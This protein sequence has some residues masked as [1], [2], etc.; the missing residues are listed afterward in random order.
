MSAEPKIIIWDLETL[1]NLTE[2]MKFMP[3]MY[4]YCTLRASLSTIICFGYKQLGWKNSKC[5]N[6]WDFPNWQK[7]VN[8]D[9]E[10]CSAAYD[11]LKDADAIVTHNGKNFDYKF[12]NARL[13]YH[14]LPTLPRMPHVDTCQVSRKKLFL[15]SNR[16]NDLA[17]F[18]S[19]EQKLDNGGWDLWVKVLNRDKP[20]M[21]LMT[22]Y[23]KQDVQVLEKVFL[24]LRG[25]CDDLPNHNLF[26]KDQKRCPKCGASRIK[27]HGKYLTKTKSY[28]RYLCMPCGSTFRT[29]AKDKIAVNGT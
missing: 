24:R 16:L 6:A 18:L 8:D 27:K 20:S 10:I 7:D 13:V 17:K 28:Q 14:G 11:I 21:D 1:S 2:V 3:R 22:R 29:D 9:Y 4:E 5:I 15:A 19:V 26:K 25:V 12:L 23:C